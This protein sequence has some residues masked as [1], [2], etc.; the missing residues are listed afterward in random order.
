MTATKPTTQPPYA[1]VAPAR[2][3]H[4]RI[5][6]LGELAMT[7][8]GV[9]RLYFGESNVPTPAYIVEAAAQALR[10]GHT[11]YS[12]NAGLPS[13]RREI[14]AQYRRLHDVELDPESRDRGHR[15]GP[16]GACT[17]RSGRRIDPGR[18]GDHPLAGLAERGGD[19]RAQP[20]RARRGAARARRRAIRDRLRRGR[21][22]PDRPDAA[23]PPHLALEP[24]RLGRA[25]GRAAAAARPLPRARP[26]ARRRRGLR[27]HLLRR[28][29][30]GRSRA[31]DHAP[32]RPRGPRP[33]RPVVLEELLHDRLAR[34]LARD[35]EPTRG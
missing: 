9:L 15:V 28:L 35:D 23:R 20:R 22:R 21:G 4:S 2:P 29:A 11:F 19:R 6:E 13:L 27:A 14:A 18:R 17:S 1:A 8:D 10:D 25:P 34:R 30:S 26:L 5:R 7:M 3:V 33:R 31:F 24:A 12:E 16:H 32:V